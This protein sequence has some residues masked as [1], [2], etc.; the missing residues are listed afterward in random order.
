MLVSFRGDRTDPISQVE[1]IFDAR[2]EQYKDWKKDDWLCTHC[3]AKLLSDN[4]RAWFDE[5]ILTE[6]GATI[7]TS[8]SHVGTNGGE[9]RSTGVH[10]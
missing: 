10:L 6:A 8:L 1:E 2:S 9:F 4:I 5:R 7:D 3:M